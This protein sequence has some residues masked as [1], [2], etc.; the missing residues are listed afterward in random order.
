[1]VFLETRD[2][3]FA[4]VANRWG[5]NTSAGYPE[6]RALVALQRGD[7]ATATRLAQAFPSADSLRRAAVGMTG[8]RTVARATVLAELGDLRRAAQLYETLDPQRFVATSIPETSWPVYVRS[9][10]ARGRLYEQLG[11]RTRAIASYERF[12]TLWKDAEAPLQPQMREAREAV[13]RLHDATGVAV[14]TG[15]R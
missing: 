11:E 7:S 3:T 8:M 12:L 5:Q 6:L 2:S 10:L 1:M 13:A 14:R 9:W 4:D 15:T